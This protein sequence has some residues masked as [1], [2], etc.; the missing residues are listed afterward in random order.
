[1]S[2]R[3]VLVTHLDE[4]AGLYAPEAHADAILAALHAAWFVVEQGWQPI[5]TAPR[6]GTRLLCYAPATEGRAAVVRNDYW[7][8]RERGF[9]LMRPTQPYTHWR[10]LPQPPKETGDEG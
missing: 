10:P 1:M 2:A 5:E 8:V 6:D 7:W 4:T 9:A 3:D